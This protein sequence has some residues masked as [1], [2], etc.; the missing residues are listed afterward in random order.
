MV[1]AQVGEHLPNAATVGIRADH[2]GQRHAPTERAQHRRHATR[3]AEPFLALL[4][5]QQDDRRFLA[6]AFGVAPDV[7][8]Q[9]EIADNQYARLAKVLHEIN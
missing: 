2:A 5:A 8:I 1:D 3:S 7:P 4:R 6:D 9:H